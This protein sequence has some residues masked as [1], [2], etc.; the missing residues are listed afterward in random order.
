MA[1]APIWLT[2]AGD[3]GIIPELEYYILS[4]DAYNPE[5]GDLTYSI[6]SGSLPA[7]L[8]L[9]NNGT[10]NGIPLKDGVA[11]V[12]SAVTKVT[13][14]TF[15]VRVT[16]TA[17]KV[18]DR[19]FS[20]TIG[21][22][23]PPVIEPE[24]GDLG[25][26]LDG[27][28]VEVQLTAI[29]QNT[30]LTTTFS[31][32][33]GTLPPGL[34]ITPEGKIYGYLTPV[35]SSQ[36]GDDTGFDG[37]AF[38]L[39]GFD[40]TGVNVSR[41]YQFTIQASDSVNIDL[42]TY[43]IYVYSRTSLTADNT[44]LDA[45]YVG[46]ITAD[47][48]NAYSP[49]LY[50]EA[51]SIDSVKQNTRYAYQFNAV[52]F[53]NDT[54]TFHLVGTLPTG[55]ILNASTGWIT[56]TVP[57][58]SLGSINYPFSIYVTNSAGMTSE[59]KNFTIKVLGQVQDQVTWVTNTN[60]GSIYNGAISDLAVSAYTISGRTLRY[61]LVA[62]STG[63]LPVG[64]DLLDS[65]LISG[66][67]SFETWSLDGNTISFD[68]GTTTI[69]QKYTF[70][71]AA[72]DTNNLVYDE[73]EFTINV[74]K[75][76]QKPYEN[77]YIQILPNRSQ[78]S[79]YDN[80]INNNDI[81]PVEYI[82]R[83]DDPWFGKNQYRQSLFL[84]G[85]NP[86]QIADYINAITLNHYWKNLNFGNVKS[87][88]ALDENFNVKYE[89]VYIELIDQQ[90]NSQGLGPNL[91]ISLPNNSA[92]IST[93]YP[94]SFPN[95]AQRVGDNI[96]YENRS[97]L[98]EWMTSRQADGTVLGFTRALVLCYTVPGRGADIAYRVQQEADV[99]RMID[100]TIDRYEWDSILST[101]FSKAP[102]TGAGNITT[103]TSSNV[104]LGYGTS[105]NDEFFANTVI[106]VN[107]VAI[108]NVETITNAT[109]MTFTTNALSTVTNSAFTYSTNIFVINNFVSG[110]GNISASNT[111]N[112]ITGQVTTITGNGTI[113]GNING[114]TITGYNTLFAAQLS[115]GKTL[116]YSGNALGI[117]SS[118]R[119]NTNLSIDTALASTLTNVAYT[120]DGSTTLFTREIHVGDTIVAPGNVILGT[121][122]TI[123]SNTNLVL[124]SNSLSTVSNVAYQHTYRDPY[125][126]P[127]EGDQYLKFP[128]VNI[129]A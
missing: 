25:T 109:Y 83:F 93:V 3:L 53:N 73:K 76:D 122:K 48:S 65:G 23:L 127:T 27:D 32:F 12:P 113:S 49:V 8:R 11:G 90:V 72:F 14:S 108:G 26:Y 69:D 34:T 117:I 68:Q 94:N 74:I 105:F 78:R 84:T 106:Y 87:A 77:L 124:Y 116:Y 13:T 58:G 62:S 43:T 5:G 110:T 60:I 18:A 47:T 126:V 31:L 38:S 39:Y 102:L 24:S 66:R 101:G 1:S 88:R 118:I 82:Y 57:Y 95:M 64:L 55:L 54:L 89:V 21:G 86:L 80:I 97:I 67:V 30:L 46:I 17:N 28:Y 50:T 99:F 85:L 103:S 4:L 125:T 10:L 20:L 15:T 123:N 75:R 81:F 128:Q 111:S 2:P 7:G 120:A 37:S 56:G 40:F 91:S 98:P 16:N 51:G 36:T 9:E 115:I 70:T 114:T 59:V 22:L 35:P 6:V 42:N 104:V 100:F 79:L 129:L 33:S 63:A 107:N 45:S 61:K 19:T 92:G 121:V 112:V 44:L 96:G 52:D 29:T 41:F 71:V 119:S